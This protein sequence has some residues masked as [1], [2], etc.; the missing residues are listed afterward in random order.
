MNNGLSDVQGCQ[1]MRGVLTLELGGS[2]SS[3]PAIVIKLDHVSVQSLG[4]DGAAGDGPPGSVVL[5]VLAAP[6][7]QD[8][9]LDGVELFYS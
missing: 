3:R 7:V 5:R 4:Q 8:Q 6:L 2:L 1:F 9:G